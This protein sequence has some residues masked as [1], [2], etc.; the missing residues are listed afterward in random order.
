[1]SIIKKNEIKNMNWEEADKRITELKKE[2]MKLN[3]Q[4]ARG[5]PAENPGRIRLIKRSVA[6]LMFI[7]NKNHGGYG[8][9]K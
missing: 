5:T 9:N 6:M 3:A 2:L 1:M 7:K 8:K 4:I